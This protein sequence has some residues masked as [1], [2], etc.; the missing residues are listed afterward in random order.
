MKLMILACLWLLTLGTA[1]AR[2]EAQE[3]PALWQEVRV[4][5]ASLS[6]GFGLP[7]RITLAK[8]VGASL[9]KDSAAPQGHASALTFMDAK[10]NTQAALEKVRNGE[11]T[12]L[13]GL[14]VLFWFGYGAGWGDEDARLQALEQ[15]LSLLDSIEC[16]LLIGDFPDMSSALAVPQPVIPPN[17]V[18]KPETLAKLNA[19]LK[20]WAKTRPR[21]VLVP[22]SELMQK[23]LKGE[24]IEIG[25][26]R[27]KAE[28]TKALLQPDGLHPNLEGTVAVW[29][30]AL[31]EL[32]RAR[33]QAVGEGCVREVATLVEALRPGSKLLVE[34]PAPSPQPVGSGK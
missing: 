1:F 17:A 13:V 11:P 9:P 10:G 2:V 4:V 29:L 16:T 6:A 19:R 32:R 14:D 5:G 31:E 20:E 7:N 22:L 3:K 30:F 8:V 28:N 27:W 25:S 15:G 23:V 18:P 33:P 34:R 12:L 24:S 21:V 26:N